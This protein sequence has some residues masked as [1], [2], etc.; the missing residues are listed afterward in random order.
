LLLLSV[1]LN[2]DRSV[3]KGRVLGS[4]VAVVPD[5]QGNT[6]VVNGIHIPNRKP[7]GRFLTGKVISIGT[8]VPEGVEVGDSVVYEKQSAH[9][10]QTGPIDA[11]LF[12]GEEGKYCVIIPVYRGALKGVGEIEEEYGRHQLEVD[13]LKEKHEKFGLTDD[14]YEK[15]GFHD[16]RMKILSEKRR[17]RAR[18][19]QRKKLTDKAKGSGVVAILEN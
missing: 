16:R 8:K 17:G 4:Y 12:G 7:P 3:M 5:L 2:G 9:P 18:G 11:S 1:Q 14:E 10:H 13:V 6:Q 15:L 19:F